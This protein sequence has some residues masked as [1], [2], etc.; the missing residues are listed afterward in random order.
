MQKY[1]YDAMRNSKYQ[2]QNC[3][4]LCVRFSMSE[5]FICTYVCT[6]HACTHTRCIQKPEEGILKLE[7]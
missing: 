2:T 7:L 3:T 6:P 1:D 5:Y 4:L